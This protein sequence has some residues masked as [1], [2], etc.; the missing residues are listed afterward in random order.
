MTP[1]VHSLLVLQSSSV[2][3]TS[4]VTRPSYTK[5]WLGS[6]PPKLGLQPSQTR[7][8]VS[9]DPIWDPSGPG[10][11]PFQARPGPQ[12]TRLTALSGSTRTPADTVY[13]P[14]GLDLDP[15]G[16]GVLPFQAR[17]GPQRTRST[18][19]LGSTWTPAYGP[20]RLD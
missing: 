15:S 4:D 17:L 16:P 20:F 8:T 18:A 12:R 7:F 13:D 5:L 1:V 10:V 6:Q 14:P 9:I 3:V 19:L 11:R 2:K